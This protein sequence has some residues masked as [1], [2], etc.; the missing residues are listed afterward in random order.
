MDK[1]YYSK[2]IISIDERNALNIRKEIQIMDHI[3]QNDIFQL[4]NCV[5]TFDNYVIQKDNIIYV[6]L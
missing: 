5:F 4:H 3:K 1:N 2:K 6:A